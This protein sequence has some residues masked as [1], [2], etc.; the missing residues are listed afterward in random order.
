MMLPSVP[1]SSLQLFAYYWCLRQIDIQNAFL[2]GVLDEDVYM[3]Q[4]LGFEDPSHPT[5]LCKLDKSLY[6][7]KQALGAWF[8]RLSGMLLK[9]GFHA[10]Q[11]DLSLSL[12]IF[13]QDGLQI[14][15]LIYVDDIIIISSSPS[16]MDKHLH[17]LHN[18]FAVKDLGRIN[19]F[20]GIELHHT[21]M[22]LILTHHKYI[23]DLLL[24]T[25]MDT[26]K[27]VSTPILP[28][29]KLS[30]RG[31]DPL[32]SGDTTKYKSMVGALQYLSFTRLD[33]SFSMNRVCQFFSVPTTSHWVTVK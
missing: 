32:S 4:P 19:Y 8:S 13:N 9:L 21:S 26:S 5:F 20:L 3:K 28:T 14:Y 31:G 18:A 25:N 24:Q 2:H 1:W 29:D 15:I 12:S 11:V 23:N 30:L 33:I 17:Q 7:L 6:G 27:G 16:A 22:G 10:S